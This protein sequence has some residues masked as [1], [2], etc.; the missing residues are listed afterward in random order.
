MDTMTAGACDD[1]DTREPD[2]NGDDPLDADPLSE[3]RSGDQATIKGEEKVTEV[4]YVN[5]R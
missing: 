4:N 3:Q 5:G 1:E 2:Q